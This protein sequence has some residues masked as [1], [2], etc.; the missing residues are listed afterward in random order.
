MNIFI[1]DLES[2]SKTGYLSLSLIQA[3]DIYI[4]LS[5]YYSNIYIYPPL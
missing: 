5:Y 4:S 3:I 2:D 1:I